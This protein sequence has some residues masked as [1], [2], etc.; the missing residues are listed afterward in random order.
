[1]CDSHRVIWTPIAGTGDAY[2]GI[3]GPGKGLMVPTRILERGG[4]WYMKD[5]L[6]SVRYA[7]QRVTSKLLV[8]VKT[9]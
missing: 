9:I 1:M 5:V 8:V 6:L 7:S 3:Q 2:I 4:G